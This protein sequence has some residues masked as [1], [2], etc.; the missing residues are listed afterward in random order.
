MQ[1]SFWTGSPQHVRCE[2]TQAS[3]RKASA[4]RWDRLPSIRGI[5]SFGPVRERGIWGA[6]MVE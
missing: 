2:K 3:Q 1:F 4:G 5:L 6:K